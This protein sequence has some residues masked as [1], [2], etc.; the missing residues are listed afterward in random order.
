MFSILNKDKEYLCLY[1]YFT[2]MRIKSEKEF[3]CHWLL[4]KMAEKV[5]KNKKQCN[6][7]DF[8]KKQIKPKE[9]TLENQLIRLKQQNTDM[10]NSCIY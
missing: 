8:F 10:G 1:Y 7:G 3:V 6:V 2:V 4:I 5:T 9:P